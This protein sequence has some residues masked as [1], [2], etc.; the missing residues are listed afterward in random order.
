M[1]NAH[2]MSEY[3]TKER[4]EEIKEEL[5]QLKTVERKRIAKRIEEAKSHGDLSEN[6]EYMEAREEQAF[7]EGKIRELEDIVR[8]AEVIEENK[9]DDSVVNVGDTIEVKRDDGEKQIFTI[10]GSNEADPMEGKI[11]NESPLG[12]AFLGRSVKDAV[13][14]TTP[15]GTTGYTIKKIN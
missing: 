2:N 8:D 11:S 6:A 5:E 15:N 13:E 7:I 14:A 3:V 1:Y 9:K 10:V 12:R 4:L